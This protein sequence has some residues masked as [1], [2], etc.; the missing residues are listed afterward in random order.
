MY[1]DINCDVGEGFGNDEEL[2]SYISSCSIACGG[3]AGDEKTMLAALKLAKSNNIK[4]GAHPSYPD[5]NNFGR[6]SLT[7]SPAE[8]KKS[9]KHQLKT[10]DDLIIK[11]DLRLHHIKP[12]GALYNDMLKDKDLSAVFLE[13][14]IDFKERVWLYVPVNSSIEKVALEKGFKIK[15]E[16]FADRNYTNDLSLV[17]RKLKDALIES[18]KDVLEHIS[19]MV[20]HNKVKTIDAS[21]LKIHA[22][23]FCIHGDTS[24]ALEIMKYLSIE[25]PKQNIYIKN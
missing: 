2:F 3:H 11:E 16:A 21:I 14:I 18:P 24:T 15:R 23:T 13:A 17:S 4:I 10:L 25:L 19:L 22:D 9:I 20:K 12:H 8:L 7:I 5:K 6:I 1:I